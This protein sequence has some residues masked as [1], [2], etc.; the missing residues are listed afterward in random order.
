MLIT[1]KPED[2]EAHAKALDET[3]ARFELGGYDQ[4]A[5]EKRTQAQALRQR[6][7]ALRHG[8]TRGIRFA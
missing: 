2:L 1:D 4:A 5:R 3:A 7:A 8:R 6:A